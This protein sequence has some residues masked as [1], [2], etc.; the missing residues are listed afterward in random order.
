MPDL[1]KA[2]EALQEKQRDAA[3][4]EALRKCYTEKMTWARGN[5]YRE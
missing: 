1:R 4:A 5:R 3:F 2:P